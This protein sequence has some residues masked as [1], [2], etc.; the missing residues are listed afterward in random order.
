MSQDRI[1]DG[2]I[3]EADLEA[4]FAAARDAGPAP[5]EAR[6][7]A[8]LLEAAL[9]AQPRPAARPGWLAR[10][11]AMLADIGGA[12]GLAGVGAAGLAGVWIGFSGPG[13]TGDLVNR[14]W[15]GAA[16]VSP[17]VSALVDADLLTGD[18]GDLLS[19]I[20]GEIE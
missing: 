9:G 5:L 6:F 16:T 18:S 7:Q 2:S 10:F 13:V 14:F 11:G 8:R 4:L 1:T 15:Q 12:P 19:F 17:T 3:P 20:T